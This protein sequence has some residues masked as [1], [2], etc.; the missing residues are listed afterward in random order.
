MMSSPSSTA[1]GSSPTCWAAQRLLELVGPVEVVLDGDL[2]PAGDHQHVVQAGRDGFLHDVLDGRLVDH[3]QHFLG[4]RLGGGQEPGA[5]ARRGD[6][7]L[8]HVLNSHA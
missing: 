8:G 2:A 3:R 6:N 7:G 5:Q 1:N 4:R